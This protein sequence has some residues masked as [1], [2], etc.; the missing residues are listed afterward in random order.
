MEESCVKLYLGFYDYDRSDL[1]SDDGEYEGG[2]QCGAGFRRRGGFLVHYDDGRDGV[3]G[4]ADGD[5][6]D[7]GADRET[8][9]GDSAVC[10]FHVSRNSEG[11]CGEGVYFYEYYC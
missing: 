11:A 4:G 10:F 8:D 3:V 2:E 1:W 6:P 7:F 5:R 9:K